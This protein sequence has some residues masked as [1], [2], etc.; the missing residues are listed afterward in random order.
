MRTLPSILSAVLVALG[1]G[2]CSG[3]LTVEDRNN[4]DRTQVL[5][6]PADLEVL[7]AAAFHTLHEGSIGQG[8]GVPIN[9]AHGLAFESCINGV[10]GIPR[11]PLGNSPIGASS[12]WLTRD[13]SA[14]S[15]AARAAAD[16]LNRLV[17][18]RV[19]LPSAAQNARLKAFAWFTLG[20]AE[21]NLALVFDSAAIADPSAD[22]VNVGP[23]L[24]YDAVMAAS[25]AALD[26]ALAWTNMA[27]DSATAWKKRASASDSFPL[28]STW[29]NGNPLTATQFLQVIHSYKAHFRADVA[30]TKEEGEAVDWPAV[31]ADATAGITADLQIT[32]QTSPT[33]SVLSCFTYRSAS[34]AAGG[35]YVNQ[36]IAGMADTSG[37][38]DTWL[39]T[40]L[41]SKTPFLVVTPDHRFPQGTTRAQQRANSPSV[42]TGVLYFRN[43]TE[44]DPSPDP[45]W[46]SYY[47]WYRF[48]SWWLNT[49]GGPYPIFSKNQNDMLRAEALIRAG[50]VAAAAALIDPWR[51]RAG[52][53]A[54]SGVIT[55]LGQPVPGGT[56]GNPVPGGSSCVPRVPVGSADATGAW[57]GTSKCGDIWEAMKWEYRM[58]NMQVGYAAWYF[59]ARRWGDLAEGTAYHFPVP[60]DEMT[61]RW[62]PYYTFGGVGA[63]GSTVGKGTYGL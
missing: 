32:T 28:P 17:L 3:L 21:G 35:Y 27:I 49:A 15:R 47:D 36:L 18:G 37:G 53:P 22:L 11:L 7:T 57:P 4:P 20:V 6:T 12:G 2:A 33:W 16:G 58:E 14:Q 44:S 19:A 8:I 54:L 51:T 24:G 10:P 42:P 56:A 43:R 41:D 38:F 40:P 60:Y 45:Y 61:A 31:L 46:N 1:L 29:I 50:D 30:R 48:R 9:G 25:L 26:S 62:Q 13:F 59:P 5:A 63:A 55:A 34:L 23:L 52:L 39:Q